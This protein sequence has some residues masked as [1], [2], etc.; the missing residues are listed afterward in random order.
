MKRWQCCFNLSQDCVFWFFNVFIT[1]TGV[2]GWER[3]GEKEK[4]RDWHP[5][6]ASCTHPDQELNWRPFDAQDDVHLTAKWPGLPQGFVSHLWHRCFRNWPLYQGIALSSLFYS[7]SQTVIESLTGWVHYTILWVCNYWTIMI[8]FNQVFKT[9]HSALRGE[10]FSSCGCW[11]T[12][13]RG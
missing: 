8:N 12:S 11:H 5:L 1:F 4:E 13:T 9:F 6:A 7:L 10:S 2:R 3:E